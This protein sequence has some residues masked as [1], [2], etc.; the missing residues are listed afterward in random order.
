MAKMYDI[1]SKITNDLPVVKISDELICT[2]NNR[3]NNILNVQAMI[4]EAERKE[5]EE[6]KDSDGTEEIRMMD[7]ALELLIGKKHTKAIN[8]MDLPV[9]EYSYVFKAVMAAA[10]GRELEENET[11]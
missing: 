6:N 8:D 1:T 2:V 11:P 3:K 5:D 7:K 9:T 4:R 10:Q